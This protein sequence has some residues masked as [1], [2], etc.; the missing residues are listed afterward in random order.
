MYL[1][2]SADFSY[3]VYIADTGANADL[4]YVDDPDQCPSVVGK[5]LRVFT[6][7][8]NPSPPSHDDLRPRPKAFTQVE[9]TPMFGDFGSLLRDYA[10]SR[11]G[12]LRI[13]Q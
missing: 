5:T 10:L 11:A 3:M 8:F 12:P 9:R 7:V 6:N 1:I 4:S 13:D 2:V